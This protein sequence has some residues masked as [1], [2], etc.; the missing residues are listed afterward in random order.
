M[1]ENVC[2]TQILAPAENRVHSR[3][4]F[5][6]LYVLCAVPTRCAS[7]KPAMPENAADAFGAAS[8]CVDVDLAALWRNEMNAVPR[9]GNATTMQCPG[10]RERG[11]GGVREAMRMT[12]KNRRV[13]G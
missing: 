3:V 9:V 6:D 10:V 2:A 11:C 5:F 1:E 13:P 8:I 4:Y 7:G 12:W